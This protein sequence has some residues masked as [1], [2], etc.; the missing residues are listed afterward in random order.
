M[1]ATFHLYTKRS[2]MKKLIILF[3]F[4]ISIVVFANDTHQIQIT[5]TTILEVIKTQ[6]GKDYLVWRLSQNEYIQQVN[7]E[8]RNISITFK[9]DVSDEI[10]QQILSV[11]NPTYKSK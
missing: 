4:F 10:Q 5:N 3:S 2:T 7:I 9:E 1:L 6:E 11:Y 8:D